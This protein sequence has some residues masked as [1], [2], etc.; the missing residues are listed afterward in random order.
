MASGSIKSWQV[1]LL[2]ASIIIILIPIITWRGFNTC[3]EKG[4]LRM[5]LSVEG[6][7]AD[8]KKASGRIMGEGAGNYRAKGY[9]V[10]LYARTDRWYPEP[11]PGRKIGLRSDCSW[12]VDGV[13]DGYRYVAFLVGKDYQPPNLI[14]E[15][16]SQEIRPL[17]PEDGE[18][19]VAWMPLVSDR[20]TPMPPEGPKELATRWLTRQITPN[21]LVSDPLVDR[22]GLIIS[23]RI[24]ESDELHPVLL[25]RSWIFD[26]ALATIGFASNGNI[27]EALTI[28]NGLKGQIQDDGKA[29]FSYNTGNDWY[30]EYYR[31]GAIAWMGYA[32]VF[33]QQETGDAQSQATAE[34]IA[35]Y[36]LSLQD[37]EPANPSYGSIRTAPDV[38]SY[39]T[40]HNIIAYFFLR[41]L[42]RLTGNDT[43]A[44]R[45]DLI[46]VSLLNHHWNEA[47]GR[48]DWKIGDSSNGLMETASLGALFFAAQGDTV[49][50]QNILDFVEDTYQPVP[51]ATP[52]TG[53]APYEDRSTIW[54]QGT[55]ETALAY[56]RIGNE[57]KSRAIIE[58]IIKLQ[59]G[60]G[61][62]P[63]A[64]PQA[65]VVT[66]EV[67]HEWPS[68]AG[69]AWLLIVLSDNRS[70]LGP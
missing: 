58:D 17:L 24:P 56:K 54:T 44:T 50:A 1:A 61:G 32:F 19:I 11:S 9:G 48:F 60:G 30:H 52:V 43:Y 7:S 22:A 25:S 34:R 8:N 15:E 10:I 14:D 20:P 45:A 46:R 13:H 63:Y 21:D 67:F 2:V 53:Y 35:G 28:L 27:V 31:A 6:P 33:Y 55:L 38:S 26:D 62:I 57:E 4:T 64:M 36:L 40:D 51:A 41:D 18:Q 16:D 68:A 39:A 29:G 3:I 12:E 42:G 59:D 49:K 66:E 37:I 69:T 70:F 5:T 65:T 47:L 23:Y